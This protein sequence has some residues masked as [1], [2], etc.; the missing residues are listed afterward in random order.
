MTEICAV[1]TSNFSF[2]Q[3]GTPLF[4]FIYI[5]FN[6]TNTSWEPV[7][8][9]E[10]AQEEEQASPPSGATPETSHNDLST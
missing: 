4:C 5:L 2:K 8:K 3:L 1:K 10:Y 7:L 9:R 6:L